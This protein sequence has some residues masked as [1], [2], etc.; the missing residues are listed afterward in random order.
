MALRRIEF[1]LNS[2]LKL[3]VHYTSGEIPLDAEPKG[4][5][6]SK[7]LPRWITLVAESSDWSGT[8]L[9]SEGYGG[10][11]PFF[12][13]YECKRL[14]QWQGDPSNYGAWSNQGEIEAPKRQ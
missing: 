13:R 6:V 11:E 12:I 7:L 5:M 10:T 1:D 14:M 3:L 2:L 9:A 4:L 8:P